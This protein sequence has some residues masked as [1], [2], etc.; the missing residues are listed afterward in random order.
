MYWN[1]PCHTWECV[2]SHIRISHVTHVLLYSTKCVVVRVLQCVA[3]CCSVLHCIAVYCSML[4][5]VTLRCVAAS[6]EHCNTLQHPATPLKHTH[7]YC[8]RS[9]TFYI[10]AHF[11]TNLCNM[12]QHTATTHCNTLQ[13][14]AT[15]HCNTLQHTATTHCN[16]LQQEPSISNTSKS[17]VSPL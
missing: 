13:H 17:H 8:N 2:T 12:L 11:M 6:T 9:H 4:Q 16:T 15:S 10:R 7:H 1:E 5:Y 3:V 14:T